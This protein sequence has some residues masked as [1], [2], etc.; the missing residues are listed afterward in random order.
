MQSLLIVN[1]GEEKEDIHG[2]PKN[3]LTLI[4]HLYY[5]SQQNV[6]FLVF[7]YIHPCYIHSF[8]ILNKALFGHF[9]INA[10][11]I[12]S[13]IWNHLPHFTIANRENDLTWCVKCEG[14]EMVLQNSESL[15]DFLKKLKAF[16]V[17]IPVH[18]DFKGHLTTRSFS[19]IFALY[20]M[21]YKLYKSLSKAFENF[22]S[23]LAEMQSDVSGQDDDD[24]D[25]A[26]L[27]VG[28]IQ[29]DYSLYYVIESSFVYDK[30]HGKY[31]Q[32]P[33]RISSFK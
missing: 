5:M 20:T 29:K 2:I 8:S 18:L 7:D 9:E 27:R 24:D 3:E 30:S 15:I 10:T 12:Q 16:K 31:E 4:T 6:F 14:Y 1:A 22:I 11:F 28:E 33:T 19:G 32:N 21:D 17:R 23:I 25:N 13:K 26:I